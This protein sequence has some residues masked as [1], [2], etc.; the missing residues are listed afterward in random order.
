MLLASYLQK[1]CNDLQSIFLFILEY[2]HW[3]TLCTFFAE[4]I[5]YKILDTFILE[6]KEK[7]YHDLSSM[8]HTA[9]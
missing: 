5:H 3:R 2:T 8:Q 9:Q 4:Y 7:L 6:Y 1:I